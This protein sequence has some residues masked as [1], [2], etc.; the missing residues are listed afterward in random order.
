MSDV[1]EMEVHAF[2]KL[3]GSN[4][5][6]VGSPDEKE[7]LARLEREL[8]QVELDY[9]AYGQRNLRLE[10]AGT[11]KEK[12]KQ[13]KMHML[14]CLALAGAC[15]TPLRH[16]VNR[17]SVLRSAGLFLGCCFLSKTFRQQAAEMYGRLFPDAMG[18]MMTNQAENAKPGSGLFQR[19]QLMKNGSFPMTPD[20]L[21]LIRVTYARQAYEDMRKP[22]ADIAKVHALYDS[23]CERLYLEGES[24]GLPRYLVD[25]SM[26]KIVGDL[27]DKDA[28]Y[29]KVFAETAYDIVSKGDPISHVQ[30]YKDAQ[31]EVK[32][33]VYQVWDGSFDDADGRPFEGPFL[34]REPESVNEL[35]HRSKQAWDRIMDQA[36]TPEEWGAAV[37]GSHARQLQQRYLT[38]IAD[39]HGYAPEELRDLNQLMDADDDVTWMLEID[40]PDPFGVGSYEDSLATILEHGPQED[41][42]YMQLGT[43][44]EFK[45]AYARW[46]NHHQDFSPMACQ[47]VA[48]DAYREYEQTGK[49]NRSY[50]T[51]VERQIAKRDELKSRWDKVF[52]NITEIVKQITSNNE[53]RLLQL[54][55]DSRPLPE[56]RG[57]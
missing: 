41:A 30:K 34:V 36:V 32:E 43:Y 42:Q 23:A 27:I 8:R 28:M 48:N 39:D 25:R 46:L 35:R 4:M 55:R 19:A 33:R 7:E 26:R 1:K 17:R 5:I 16:G 15:L 51:V 52:K 56:V 9:A 10:Q 24:V 38:Y 50:L 21:A 44:P 45:S 6:P 40:G 49:T 12:E 47:R 11:E 31:G 14:F 37:S 29:A 57:L 18:R 22:G 53:E 20:S 13:D 54:R 2:R 3:S